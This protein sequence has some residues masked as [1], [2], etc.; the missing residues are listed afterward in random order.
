MITKTI[1]WKHGKCFELV[2]EVKDEQLVASILSSRL[3]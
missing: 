3:V 2:V 1:S